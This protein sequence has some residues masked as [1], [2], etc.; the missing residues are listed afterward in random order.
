MFPESMLFTNPGPSE[1]GVLNAADL[2]YK[3][4]STS[5]VTDMLK[6]SVSLT[7]GI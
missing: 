2:P 5:C 7:F 3:M 1:N 4:T 6:C